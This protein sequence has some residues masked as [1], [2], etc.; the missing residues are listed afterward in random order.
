MSDPSPIELAGQI[1]SAF[2]ASREMDDDAVAELVQEIHRTLVGL[3]EGPVVRAER[4]APAVHPKPSVFPDYIVCLEDGTR[5]KMLKRYLRTRYGLTPNQLSGEMGVTEGIPDGRPE[6][7]REAKRTGE[8][9]RARTEGIAPPLPYG[10]RPMQDHPVQP[11]HEMHGRWQRTAFRHAA[12][13]ALDRLPH[14]MISAI[15]RYQRR[16][17]NGAL[18]AAARAGH[19]KPPIQEVSQRSL[20][21]VQAPGVVRNVEAHDRS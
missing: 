8:G 2:S 10:T 11:V 7:W 3:E 21:D 15:T 13:K 1:V 18:L 6:L 19:E 17:L 9:E 12:A 16:H 5:L 4:P 14:Q 20:D